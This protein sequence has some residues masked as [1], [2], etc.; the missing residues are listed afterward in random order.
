[1]AATDTQ[2]RRFLL[3]Q[4]IHD[5]PD[6]TLTQGN[7][8]VWHSATHTIGYAPVAHLEDLWSL[9]H[10]LAH[11]QLNHTNYSRDIGLIRCEAQAWQHAQDMLA[12]RYSLVIDDNFIQDS[13]DTYRLWLDSRSRCPTCNQNGVQTTTNTYSCVNCR[14]L[15]RVNDARGC[16]L[17]R[18]RLQ[19]RSE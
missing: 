10:E 1:M 5:F 4:I 17:Q 7:S 9:L 15:W 2:Q 8:F 16:R 14:C 19:V 11:A 18:T 13:L 3:K 12:P 6:Y